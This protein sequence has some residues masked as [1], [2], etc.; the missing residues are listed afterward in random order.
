[1]KARRQPSPAHVYLLL[2]FSLVL[3]GDAFA[4]GAGQIRGQV[5]EAATGEPLPGVNVVVEGTQR[6]AATNADG[7][8]AIINVPIGTQAVRASLIGYTPVTQTDVLVKLDQTSRVNFTLE[9]AVIEGQEIVI[10]AEQDILHKEVSATQNVITSDQVL[11]AAAVRNLQDFVARQ[12]GIDQNLAIR[13]GSPD[14]TGTLINGMLFGNNDL[15]E[16]NIGVPL[17]AVEQIS[18]I[19]GGYTAEEGNFRSGLINVT[20]RTG[21]RDGYHGRAD[22][23]KNIPHMKRFGQS[24]FDVHNYYL[25]HTLDPAI[26]FEGTD[27]ALADDPYLA[28][29]SRTFKGW[30]AMAQE[31]NANNTFEKEITPLDLYLWEAWMHAVTP[32]WD[33]LEARGYTVPDEMK[34]RIEEHARPLESTYGDYNID[35]GFGGPVP[36][37]GDATFYLSHNSQQE[38]YVV[39]SNV[40]MPH[41]TSRTTML[42]LQTPLSNSLTLTLNGL[43]GYTEGTTYHGNWN[44]GEYAGILPAN[45]LAWGNAAVVDDVRPLFNPGFLTPKR[46]YTTLAGIELQHMIGDNTF[47]DF[48]FSAQQHKDRAAEAWAEAGVTP[49]EYEARGWTNRTNCDTFTR[50]C[51]EPVILF[52]PAPA[53]NQPYGY[54]AGF[55]VVNGPF[56]SWDY[57]LV[58]Q[59]PGPQEHRWDAIG[60]HYSDSTV[61]RQYHTELNLTSQVSVH[62]L[63]KGGVEFNLGEYRKN[64]QFNNFTITH[65]NETFI[66]D[67]FPWRAGA[68]IQDQL[69]YEGVVANLGVRADYYHPTGEWVNMQDPEVLYSDAVFGLGPQREDI[70]ERWDSLGVIQEAKSHFALS[71]RIGFSFPVTVKAKFFFNY[72]HFRSL[73]PWSN[74]FRIH[75]SSV[76]EGIFEVGAPNLAPPRTISYETGVDYNLLDQYLVRISGYY[77]DITGEAG[78]IEYVNALGTASYGTFAN[79]NYEDIMGVELSVTKNLGRW[80]SGWANFDFMLE[81]DGLVGRET[82]FEDPSRT[83]VFGLYEGQE[84]RPLPRPRFNANIQIHTPGDFGPAW[85][86][87]RPLG[88]WML[89][90]LPTWRLG[91]YDTWNPLG[92]L[93]LQDNV[94]WPNYHVWDMRVT[95]LMDFGRSEVRF[96]TDVSNVFNQEITL[97][98]IGGN[99]AAFSGGSD[100]RDYMASL[101]L[102]MYDSPEFDELRANSPEGYYTPG[103]DTPG[104]LR[105][106]EKPYIND[107]NKMNL[108]GAIYPRDIWF[109]LTVSF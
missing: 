70:W 54:S 58:G 48:K 42:T 88:D 81:K 8:Y 49:A 24:L 109:G 6:G 69:E 40:D 60:L 19:S 16:P 82:F 63:L 72:G 31:L 107:P 99:N 93:H 32:P 67:K 37:L 97:L 90:V 78:Q 22:V 105:S 92:E 76:Q 26:A 77:K 100:F 28:G 38:A 35:V 104:E 11:E 52:G 39:P 1:M 62:H 44:G 17:S 94:R 41:R 9:E 68:Y 86:A 59:N 50:V 30:N 79:N 2:I 85:G 45:N 84:S 64:V 65:E 20:T 95:K 96:Y 12:A 53:V 55:T 83:A 57:G 106:A 46:R 108:W 74:L 89:S 29:Q 15:D 73:V 71:P 13:G 36:L 23:S 33:E 34:R 75:Y 101:H 91:E 87:F 25:R 3:A 18:V 14:E 51:D 27:V 66:W 5:L 56:G 21:R 4:Q 7:E 61:T 47:W 80:F 98:H 103:N 102:P 10:T 43:Y